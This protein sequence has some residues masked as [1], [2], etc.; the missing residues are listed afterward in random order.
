MLVRVS[1]CE[2]VVSLPS[3]LSFSPRLRTLNLRP[4]ILLVAFGGEAPQDRRP[5]LVFCTSVVKDQEGH[6]KGALTWKDTEPGDLVGWK[7]SL[8]GT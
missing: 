2:S 7:D 4:P 1:P 5:A 6:G 3:W 8:T